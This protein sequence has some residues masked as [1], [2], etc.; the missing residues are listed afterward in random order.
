MGSEVE[1]LDS[2]TYYESRFAQYGRRP[3]TVGWKTH[4]EALT[5]YRRVFQQL[6]VESVLDVG[7]GFGFMGNWLKTCLPNVQ[8][9]AVEEVAD[10]AEM[11][12][13]SHKCLCQTYEL[14]VDVGQY[15]VVCLI[16]TMDARIYRRIWETRLI[17]EQ[18]LRDAPKVVWAGFVGGGQERVGVF[19]Y[20]LHT[21][22]EMC[23]GMGEFMLFTDNFRFTL[24]LERP[25]A[26]DRDRS[27]DPDW[28]GYDSRWEGDEDDEDDGPGQPGEECVEAVCRRWGIPDRVG[29]L[30]GESGSDCDSA[31]SSS[32]QREEF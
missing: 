6:E 14:G 19:K 12:S 3:A 2:S 9:T 5:V 23:R 16:H 15:D 13:Q 25:D 32:V 31:G 18:A 10:F 7:A 21:V 11:I 30:S 4:G 28:L 17:L 29:G 26:D 1:L 24:F 22:L 27:I 20:D 8:Y